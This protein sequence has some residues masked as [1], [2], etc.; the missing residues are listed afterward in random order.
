MSNAHSKCHYYCKHGEAISGTLKQWTY[1]WGIWDFVKMQILIWFIWGKAWFLHFWPDPGWYQSCRS[2]DHTLGNEALEHA[3]H[4]GRPQQSCLAWLRSESLL[5]S[6]WIFTGVGRSLSHHSCQVIYI[7]GKAREA[8]T[9]CR[10][11]YTLTGMRVLQSH[12][13]K[14]LYLFFSKH[15][16]PAKGETGTYTYIVLLGN[17]SE[18]C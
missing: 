6:Y 9:G 11:H 12:I 4:P 10:K 3:S 7:I 1:L 15:M 18:V 8:N 2:T 13:L 17:R 14:F 16:I 5:S